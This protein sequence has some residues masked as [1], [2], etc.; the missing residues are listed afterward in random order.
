MADVID[1]LESLGQDATLRRAS[2]ES[3]LD[4]VGGTGL[5]AQVRAALVN[6]DQG[7]LE[8]LLGSRNVCCMIHAPLREDE[9]APVPEKTCAA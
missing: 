5:S 3:T 2:L 4:R 8:A 1:F 7:A 9:E 6:R